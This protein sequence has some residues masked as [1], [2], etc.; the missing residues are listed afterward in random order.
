MEMVDNEI[1]MEYS[2]GENSQRIMCKSLNDSTLHFTHQSL[3]LRIQ[4]V[5]SNPMPF[6]N[7][8]EIVFLY[9]CHQNNCPTTFLARIMKKA[10]L[11]IAAFAVLSACNSSKKSQGNGSVEVVLSDKIARND[12]TPP[13]NPV[14]EETREPALTKRV[15][16]GCLKGGG[17]RYDISMTIA[18][19]GKG[20]E[21]SSSFSGLY[22][23]AG[24]SDFISLEGD[25]IELRGI[26]YMIALFSDRYLERFDLEFN[27]S[28]LNS[29]TVLSGTWSQYANEHDYHMAYNP[30]KTLDVELVLQ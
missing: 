5:C 15:F 14:Y 21:Y 19:S 23:Y 24:H 3:V 26:G 12:I 6:L 22:R 13:A 1:V 11:L 20:E 29:T 8:G 2:L 28:D 9:I 18:F 10:I 17:K 30:K 7:R 25:W 27:G 16:Y 4:R